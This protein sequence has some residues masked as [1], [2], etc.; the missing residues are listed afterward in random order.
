MGFFHLKA[1]EGQKIADPYTGEIRIFAGNY[2]PRDWA[3]CDGSTLLIQ[4]HA[5]LYS[6]IG[7]R[8]GGNG[9]TDFQ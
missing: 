1:K 8:F 2:A 6:V 4:Q 5:V 9:K 3:F 7:N